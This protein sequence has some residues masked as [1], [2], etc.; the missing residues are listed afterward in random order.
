M[1][2][3][4]HRLERVFGRL[5]KWL[6]PAALASGIVKAG[7]GAQQVDAT[8]VTAVLGEIDATGD[9]E[10]RDPTIQDTSRDSP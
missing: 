3:L 2:A 6:A 5:N 9:D 1:R 4:F 7:P 8:H 10:P